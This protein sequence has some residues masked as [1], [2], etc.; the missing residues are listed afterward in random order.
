MLALKC[1]CARNIFGQWR[2]V[3]CHGN[4]ML[5]Q[6][7]RKQNFGIHLIA[8]ITSLTVRQ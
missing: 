7:L 2:N 3:C 8:L 5:C 4:G 6:K 1:R